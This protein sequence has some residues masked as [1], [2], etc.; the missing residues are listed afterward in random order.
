M[1]MGCKPV[2]EL[3][4]CIG[5]WSVYNSLTHVLLP[6]RL[7]TNSQLNSF[8]FIIVVTENYLEIKVSA[9]SRSRKQKYQ[10]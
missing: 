6:R 7:H 8:R 1:I 5:L 9:A 4:F 3:L 10:T 2:D